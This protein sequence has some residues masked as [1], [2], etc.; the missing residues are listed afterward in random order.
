MAYV[1]PI[2]LIAY[3][4]L[5]A[6]AGFEILRL[7]GIIKIRLEKRKLVLLS[8]VALFQPILYFMF[9]TFGLNLTSSS[10]AGMMIAIIPIFVTIIGSLILK[11][12]P[13]TVQIVFISISVTGIILIQ[14]FKA[15][16]GLTGSTVGFVLLLMAV[17]SAAFF[18]IVS[19]KASSI[20]TPFEVTYVMMLAGAG[21]FNIIYLI[22]LAFENRVGDYLSNLRHVELV[23]P[24]VYLGLVA[25]IGGFF[26]VNYTLGKLPAHVSSIYSNLS[27]IVAIGA[28]AL[29]LHEQL[30]FYHYLGSALILIGVYGTIRFA[31]RKTI[32]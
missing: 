21:A 3:R 16:G 32:S 11:E 22:Q 30:Q 17:L 23:L 29:I 6:Y 8:L 18:N 14:V 1:S 5:I 25:S 27:T 26:L 9:E 12:K 31:R 24:L 19:R 2:G 4:F 15:G 10:E 7:T 20:S 13:T 28:G